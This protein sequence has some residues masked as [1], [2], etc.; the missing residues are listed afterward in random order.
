MKKV[1]LLSVLA[2]AAGAAMS[3]EMGRVLSSTPVVQQVAVP[4]QVCSNEQVLTAP[5]RSG[6]GA[7]MGAIAGGAMGNAVGQGS[8]RAVATMI[9]LVGGAMVGDRIEGGGQPQW[10][11]V[12]QCTTQT[13]YEN[14]AVAYNVVYEYAGRQ[15]QVQLPNDPGAY[16]PVQVTPV[17]AALAPSAPPAVVS[18]APVYTT[19]A[20]VAPAPVYYAAPAYAYPPVGVSLNLGYSRGYYGGHY[21]HGW[22]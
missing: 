13:S 19:P 8:G 7:V 20:Y 4:R 14:R 2:V 6:A 5:P 22:R 16:V 18:A 21:H 10:Q 12:P 11:N 17:G 15:Y 9:G 3:Q 1:V